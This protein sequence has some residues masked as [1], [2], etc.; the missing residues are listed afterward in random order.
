MHT[1]VLRQLTGLKAGKKVWWHAWELY[2]HIYTLCVFVN[3]E[4]KQTVK[5]V[6][7]ENE[8]EQG[9]TCLRVV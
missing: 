3:C 9:E 1:K 5:K 4:N 7:V 2:M 8:L 6:N